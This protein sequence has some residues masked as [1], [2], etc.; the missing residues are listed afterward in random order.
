MRTTRIWQKLANRLDSL[1]SGWTILLAVAF[2]AY[3]LATIMPAQST[4]SRSYAGDWGGPDR[5]FYYTPDELYAQVSTWGAAG[6]QQYVDF[7]LGLDIGF[8]LAYT[9]FLITITGV[10]IRKAWPGDARRRLLLLLPLVPMSCDLLENALGIWLV[11]AFPQRLDAAAWFATSI[12]ALKWLSLAAAHGV[13][14]YA[15]VAAAVR[16]AC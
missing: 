5:H 9:A 13:M 16:R 4:E 10:A 2:Y 6:R 1:S 15:L 14:L 11:S 12:T 8:A 7:R 3:F